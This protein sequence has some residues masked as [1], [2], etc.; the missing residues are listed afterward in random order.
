MFVLQLFSKF[1]PKFI[2]CHRFH[3]THKVGPWTP[4]TSNPFNVLSAVLK[5]ERHGG[6]LTAVAHWH[7]QYLLRQISGWRHDRA[8]GLCA[9]E[10]RTVFGCGG[11]RCIVYCLVPPYGV[12]TD[13]E[14]A[15]ASHSN[16]PP[17]IT[18]LTF[19]LRS[20]CQHSL[21]YSYKPSCLGSFT[22]GVVYIPG[23]APSSLRLGWSCSH[24][25]RCWW[26]IGLPGKSLH[27]FFLALL[28]FSRSYERLAELWD[29]LSI[30]MNTGDIGRAK[31]LMVRIVLQV[32]EIL[33]LHFAGYVSEIH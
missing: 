32:G 24:E 11:A 18:L 17:S 12:V 23:H 26:A 21:K 7:M 1:M 9:Y 19:T 28:M 31:H 30:T 5:T 33:L 29:E 22:L 20:P 6:W 4:L 8:S 27:L 13:I 15:R 14:R 16:H 10:S 2:G 25:G 3:S